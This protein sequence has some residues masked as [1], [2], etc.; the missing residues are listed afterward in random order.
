[1]RL[2]VGLLVLALILMA[3]PLVQAATGYF[4]VYGYGYPA[5]REH[6]AQISHVKDRIPTC[7]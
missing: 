4:I 7:G 2:F 1:M 5:D 6:F 3:A